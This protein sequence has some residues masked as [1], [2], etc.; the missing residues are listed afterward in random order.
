MAALDFL[1]VSWFFK[2]AVA[3][4]LFAILRIFYRLTLHPLAKFPGPK[5]AGATSLY[6]ASYDLLNEG[7]YV[8]KLPELHD[9]YGLLFLQARYVISEDG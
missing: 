8:K 9:R 4:I 5:L 2:L 6:A 1:S 3:V 7:T